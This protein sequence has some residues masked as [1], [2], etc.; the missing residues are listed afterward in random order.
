MAK[1]EAG[2]ALDPELDKALSELLQQAE[3]EAISP[4]L[5]DLAQQLELA[6]QRARNRHSEGM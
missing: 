4:R 5:R 1:D 2:A 6:L 3:K